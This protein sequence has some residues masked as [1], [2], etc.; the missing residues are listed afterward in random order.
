MHDTGGE[1]LDLLL[2]CPT[3]GENGHS[4]VTKELNERYHF[5]FVYTS[6]DASASL[7]AA[8]I[9]KPRQL[10]VYK[11]QALRN[12]DGGLTGSLTDNIKYH[13]SPEFSHLLHRHPRGGE[14]VLAVYHRLAEF[15]GMLME[16]H[17]SHSVALVC[18]QDIISLLMRH[19]LGL[20][21][22]SQINFTPDP[23]SI[24]HFHV[25]IDHARLIC[26][27]LISP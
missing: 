10:V 12:F 11:S 16:Y 2:I 27:N 8:S 21:V 9:A 19:L 14:S 13:P 18:H 4:R 22:G 24:S 17:P 3:K 1:V 15:C 7:T 25:A 5:E 20:P 6:P 26:F 23:G